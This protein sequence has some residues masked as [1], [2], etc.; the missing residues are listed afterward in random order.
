LLKTLLCVSLL[1]YSNVAFGFQSGPRLAVASRLGHPLNHFRKQHK[2]ADN[3]SS[4]HVLPTKQQVS[5]RQTIRFLS[6]NVE[7][8][9]S[10]IKNVKNDNFFDPKMTF[11]LVGGQSLL[12]GIAVG[13]AKIFNIPNF[14]L[15]PQIDLSLASLQ[16]GFL[17]SLPMG[18]FAVLLDQVEDRFPALQDVT[19][20]THKSVLTLLGG[21]FKPLL[22]VVIALALGFAAG[23]GEE[24]LFRGVL[25]YGLAAK[26]G[27]VGSL[28]VASVIFGALHAVTPLYALLAG[29]AS[30]YFGYLYLCFGNLAVP[31]FAHALY[32][33]GALYY[34]HWEVSKMTDEEK[35]E[36]ASL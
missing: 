11:L 12:I 20:A 19:K 5:R 14:G 26:V 34:A 35:A 25:Q 17:M 2:N 32:D 27:T 4:P 33:V 9:D 8:S 7:E 6:E 22:G 30:V 15:G 36:L 3:Q 10:S 18:G 21:S 1:S 29:I 24:M 28:V 23:F 13:F 31:I 16:Q